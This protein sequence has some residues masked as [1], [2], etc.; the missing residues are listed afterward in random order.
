ML[1]VFVDMDQERGWVNLKAHLLFWNT[2]AACLRRVG[3]NDDTATTLAR[4]FEAAM[5][6]PNARYCQT[7]E[8]TDE[9]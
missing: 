1:Q 7:T 6:T 8:T 4:S 2:V 9:P 5:K 3:G